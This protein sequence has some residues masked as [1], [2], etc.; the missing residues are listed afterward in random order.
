MHRGGGQVDAGDDAID[1]AGN[2][3]I[4]SSNSISEFNSSGSPLSPASG[5]TAA[6]INNPSFVAIDPAGNVWIANGNSKHCGTYRSRRAGCDTAGC[7]PDAQS[8]GGGLR[9]IRQVHE[10]HSKLKPASRRLAAD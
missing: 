7:L 8:A 1:G 6:G 9:A 10:Q 5:F 4:A 2:I 3:W